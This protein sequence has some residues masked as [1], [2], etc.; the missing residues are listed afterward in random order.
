MLRMTPPPWPCV[1]LTPGRPALEFKDQCQQ[2]G[3]IRGFKGLSPRSLGANF[4]LAMACDC[5]V[6]AVIP[7]E[8]VQ[9]VATEEMV[10][11]MSAAGL[12]MSCHREYSQKIIVSLSP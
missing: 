6:E 10:A 3:Y 4:A 5:S 9:L 12:I 8:K 2:Q 11:F 7:P 1:G